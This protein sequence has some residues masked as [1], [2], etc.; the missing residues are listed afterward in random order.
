MGSG[1]L[2]FQLEVYRRNYTRHRSSAEPPGTSYMLDTVVIFNWSKSCFV[3]ARGS[4]PMCS[5]PKALQG[6][7]EVAVR[8]LA[9]CSWDLTS[10]QHNGGCGP[11]RSH[12]VNS[13]S[14]LALPRWKHNFLR[15]NNGQQKVKAQRRRLYL[16]HIPITCRLSLHYFHLICI[17]LHYFNYFILIV[18]HCWRSLWPNIFLGISTL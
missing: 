3:T 11:C 1:A 14:P 2:L 6:S 13:H 12:T 5:L 16:Y 10:Q 7:S 8:G 15:T 4:M 9:Y 17:Y 18:L